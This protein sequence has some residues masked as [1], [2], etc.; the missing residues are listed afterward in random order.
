MGEP[1]DA[2][3]VF[4]QSCL[5]PSQ[6]LRTDTLAWWPVSSPRAC[7]QPSPPPRL[8]ISLL[9]PLSPSL[10][11]LTVVQGVITAPFLSLFFLLNHFHLLRPSFFWLLLWES[12][13]SSWDLGVCRAPIPAPVARLGRGAREMLSNLHQG[14]WTWL[15]QEWTR[16][17]GSCLS[18]QWG[19]AGLSAWGQLGLWNM[20]LLLVSE[21]F[22]GGHPTLGSGLGVIQKHLIGTCA[23]GLWG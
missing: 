12:V 14:P 2:A 22:K 19:S 23:V 3:V 10:P 11:I 18:S 1:D 13:T 20:F 4:L 6:A 9:A 16:G 7:P 15:G 5:P 8:P 21:R 17:W